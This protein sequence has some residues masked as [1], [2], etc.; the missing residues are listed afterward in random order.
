MITADT[1]AP[2]VSLLPK[3][4]R[5]SQAAAARRNEGNGPAVDSW[6]VDSGS[7]LDLVDRSDAEPCKA[8]VTTG[9][10]VRLATANGETIA[11]QVLPLDLKSLG[12]DIDPH[13]LA[14][15]MKK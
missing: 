1:V 5:S 2:P 10:R 15:T 13:V 12:E 14:S 3:L 6:L 7:P 8:H 4:P 11:D 9:T